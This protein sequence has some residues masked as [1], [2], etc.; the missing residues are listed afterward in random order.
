MAIMNFILAARLPSTVLGLCLVFAGERYFSSDQMGAWLNGLGVF[1]LVYGVL[2]AGYRYIK[3]RREG[4]T[5]ECATWLLCMVWQ[6]QLA[7]ACALYFSYKASLGDR[8]FPSSLSEK[9]LLAGWLTIGGLGLFLGLGIEWAQIRNGRGA[10]AEP[11]R[12]RLSATNWL[13]I[14]ILTVILVCVNY[15]AIK[16]NIGWDLSYLRTSRPSSSTLQMVGSISQKFDVA[17]FFPPGNEVLSKARLYFDD[18]QKQKPDLSISFFDME[19]NPVQADEYKVTRNGFVVVR[20]GELSERFDLGLTLEAA[21]KGLKNLDVEFQRAVTGVTQRRKNIYFTRGHGELS[22]VSDEKDSNGLKTIKKLEGFLRSSGYVLRFFG[23]SDGAAMGVPPDADAIV[24]MGGTQPFLANEASVIKK[25]VESGG[26]LL[27]MLDVDVS[28]D[29]A[30]SSGVRDAEKDP[31]VAWLR[32]SGVTFNSRI[33]ANESNH[34][35]ATGSPV[36][37][38]F[39]YTNVFTS[40]ASVQTLARNEERAALISLKSGFFATKDDNSKWSV[41]DTVRSLSDTFIDENKDFRFNEKTE[42]REPR[43]LGVALEQKHL[44]ND[45]GQTGKVVAFADSTAMSDA[46][47]ENQA[48]L[49]YFVDSL[50]WLLGEA[51]TIRGLATSEDDVPIRHSKKEDLVWFYSTVGFV[52]ALVLIAGK[53]ATVRAR[54]PRRS[55]S[56]RE[57]GQK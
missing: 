51:A 45:P 17:V 47:I 36:D 24:V 4:Q 15:V 8:P 25:Y 13:K 40:H 10:F 18:L 43:V 38:W 53:Y 33:L 42:T 35:K 23:L 56:L 16:K 57:K 3:T 6:L 5:S 46:L 12:I 14:G 26:K 50:R 34:V 48:N 30:L 21:R 49:V 29:T 22:W 11:A 41:Y 2:A 54:R 52:P 55:G 28:A 20:S 32:D 27:M 39:L 9:M 37:V 1:L 31:L 19:A 7:V 44:S